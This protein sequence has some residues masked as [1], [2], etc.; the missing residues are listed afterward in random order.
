MSCRASSC[1]LNRD[2]NRS[3]HSNKV[4]LLQFLI[5]KQQR[6]LVS[7]LRSLTPILVSILFS[8]I[9]SIFRSA[10]RWQAYLAGHLQLRRL[11]KAAL[12]QTLFLQ[13]SLQKSIFY[14]WENRYFSVGRH[15]KS[16]SQKEVFKYGI[17]LYLISIIHDVR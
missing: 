9:N 17:L 14:C 13:T 3:R 7:F 11:L 6:P 5:K 15:I 10:C 8:I 1:F 4:S 2:I 12:F 16:D